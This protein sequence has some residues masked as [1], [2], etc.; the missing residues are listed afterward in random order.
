MRQQ[1]TNRLLISILLIVFSFA[2]SVSA[3]EAGLMARAD[4]LFQAGKFAA[5]QTLYSKFNAKN[6]KDFNSALQLGRI[7]MLGNQFEPAQKWLER[8]LLQ[9]PND[10]DAKI[11]LAEVFYRQD[12]FAKAVVALSGMI[13]KMQA[14]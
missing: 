4:E 7:F 13:R 12:K 10:P 5:A 14:G 6:P 11:M 8:A 3:Q 2:L 9:K 1:H